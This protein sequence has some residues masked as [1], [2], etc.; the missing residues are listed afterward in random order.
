MAKLPDDVL[1]KIFELKPATDYKV[2]CA[3]F[4]EEISL[5]KDMPGDTRVLKVSVLF[6]FNTNIDDNWVRW[7]RTREWKTYHIGIREFFYWRSRKLIKFERIIPKREDRAT[8][9]EI[10][11]S[12]DGSYRKTMAD[13]D[14]R[15]E[16]NEIIPAIMTALCKQWFVPSSYVLESPLDIDYWNKQIGSM[17]FLADVQRYKLFSYF[18]M[19][20]QGRMAISK[21]LTTNK[22]KY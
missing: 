9:A 7:F 8:L 15:D 19:K 18:K 17:E 10:T 13:E 22:L 11:L 21:T 2:G 5:E 14:V 6:K 12:Y 3:I 4:V 1:S 16:L 20:V